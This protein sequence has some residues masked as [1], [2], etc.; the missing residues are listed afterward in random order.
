MTLMKSFVGAIICLLFAA[1]LIAPLF[2]IVYL[3]TVSGLAAFASLVMYL[4]ALL[5][6]LIYLENN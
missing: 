5:T 2:I 1:F 4:L 3:T 6:M